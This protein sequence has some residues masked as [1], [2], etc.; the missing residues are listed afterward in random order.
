ML[1]R[2]LLLLLF[3]ALAEAGAAQVVIHGEVSD[4]ETGQSLPAAHVSVE[5]RTLGTITNAE[6]RFELVLPALP[7]T[8]R[9]RYIGYAIRHL[10]VRPGDPQPLYVRL[11]PAVYS[12][13]ELFVTDE[14]FAENV[15]RRV[16]ER[17]KVWRADLHQYQARG[18][19]RLTLAR[20]EEINLLSEAVY[21]VYWDRERGPREVVRSRRE[22][23]D[24]YRRLGLHEAGYVQNFYD[25]YVEVQGL[26]FIGPTHPDALAYY[27]FTFAGRRELEGQTVYD[28]YVAPKTGVEATFVGRIA[29]LDSVYALLE[30]ELRPARHVTFPEPVE[31]WA[32]MYRQQFV[33]VGEAFWMPLDLRAEG[34]IHVDPDGLGYQPATFRQVSQLSSYQTDVRLPEDVYAQN[35]RVTVDEA[36]VFD[37]YLF[38]QGR[39]IVPLTPLETL[40]LE[41][42]KE[43]PITLEQALQPSTRAAVLAA[44][45]ARR[46]EIDGPQ[47]AWPLILGYEPWFRFNR[48]DGYF[49]GI[50]QTL[51]LSPETQVEVRAAQTTG[52]E[53]IRFL[54]RGT[55]RWGRGGTVEATYVRDTDAQA[56]GSLYPL[57]LASLPPL[58]GGDDYFDYFWNR[59]VGLRLGYAFPLVRGTVSVRLEQHEAAERA[60]RRAWPFEHAFRANPLVEEGSLRA[61]TASLASGDGFR[62]FRT[63]PLRRVG[64]DIEHAL[65]DV[66]GS[67]FAF[68]RATLTVDGDVRTLFRTRLRPSRLLFRVVA[69]TSTGEVPLQRLGVL[70]GTLGPFSTLGAFRSLRGRPY[71]GEQHV[72]AF[73]E[74]DFGTRPFSAL[75][76]SVFADR[77][78]GVQ[79][80]GGHGRTW[81]SPTRQADL[82]PGARYQGRLHHELGLA[83]TDVWGTPLRLDLTYRL[84]RPGFYV[85]FGLSRL[86]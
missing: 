53:H 77:K 43:R 60:Q 71:A 29:V 66:L 85:G 86:K 55:R 50:G 72:G 40:A 51:D 17:K 26:R 76:L 6:G 38:L 10:D 25:D 27:T 81:L 36:S 46:N 24:F 52:L 83:L 8:I 58:F 31:A 12:L 65:P 11:E 16:I 44:F 1:K 70:D 37:D 15:M 3:S 21:D 57:P 28:L 22:T 80:F 68:T 63:G 67:D 75:G 2:L 33:S 78:M 79:L 19:T 30:A 23:A 49:L 35:Q 69:G 73:W 39:Y 47:F 61:V 34:R 82:P 74:H 14:D 56:A 84:D 9:V 42:L 41:R 62:P 18:Y 32:V 7:V 5:G 54:A 4:A 64:I 59:R 20:S 45:S 13:G 48:V